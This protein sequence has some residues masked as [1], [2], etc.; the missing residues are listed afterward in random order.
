MLRVF[1]TRA[2]LMK[3]KNKPIILS[4]LKK[5]VKCK[6]LLRKTLPGQG[7]S[8]SWYPKAQKGVRLQLPREKEKHQPPPALVTNG[9][10]ARHGLP[11]KV[12]SVGGD[13]GDPSNR[14]SIS[15]A[16]VA[17]P[18]ATRS[19]QHAGF[20]LVLPSG[21]SRDG[22][23]GL[24]T[25]DAVPSLYSGKVLYLPCLSICPRVATGSST[26]GIFQQQS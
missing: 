3:M 20:A 25:A 4:A 11:P 7:W 22:P 16:M 24:P 18:T 10:Q 1:R 21:C 5:K 14:H 17:K 19:G 13:R 15:L 23:W 26:M 12:L 8:V 6:E 9:P 2:P